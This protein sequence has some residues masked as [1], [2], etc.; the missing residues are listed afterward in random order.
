VIHDLNVMVAG[1]GGDGSLTV[2]GLLGDALGRRGFRLHESRS[3]ASRVKGGHAAGYLR[4]STVERGGLGDRLDLLVAFDDDAVTQGAP[5]LR[6]DGYVIHDA[7]D[8]PARRELLPAGATV[9]EIPF[10]RLVVRDL[11]R[12]LYKNSLAFGVGD[13]DQP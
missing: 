2:V 1:Q 5:L 13:A 3:V 11:R 10:G 9:L 12:D 4:A 7:S 6:E 8:G